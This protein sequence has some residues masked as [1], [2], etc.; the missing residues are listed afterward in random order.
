MEIADSIIAYFK[1]EGSKTSD[2]PEGL[3]PVCWGYQEYDQKIRTIFKDKQVDINN[4][5]DSYMLIQ[6]FVNENI[7]GIHLKEGEV[8]TCPQCDGKNTTP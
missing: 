2:A 5:K 7:D 4:H 1:S 3:C 8:H 6:S